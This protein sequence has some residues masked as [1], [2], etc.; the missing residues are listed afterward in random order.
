M[1]IMPITVNGKE[2]SAGIEGHQGCV[3]GDD[4]GYLDRLLN[5][6]VNWTGDTYAD[7]SESSDVYGPPIIQSK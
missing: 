4:L 5:I 3:V 1:V 6:L 7:T 2:Y